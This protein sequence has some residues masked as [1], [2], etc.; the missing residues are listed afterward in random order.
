ME[1]SHKNNIESF[2]YKATDKKENKSSYGSKILDL[3]VES[4][5]KSSGVIF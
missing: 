2:I 1:I 3:W 4:Q 5:C